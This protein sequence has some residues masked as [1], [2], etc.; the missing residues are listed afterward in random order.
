MG[1]LLNRRRYMGGGS[2]AMVEIEYLESTGTQYIKT[3]IIPI[4]SYV[5]ISFRF[6]W[7]GNTTNK[8]ETVFGFIKQSNLNRITFNKYQG[9]WMFGYNSTVSM[10]SVDSNIH[11]VLI[12]RYGE[13]NSAYFFC[14]IDNIRRGENKINAGQ[15]SLQI[16]LFG[17]NQSGT[18]VDNL[19]EI[20]LMSFHAKIYSDTMLQE[21]VNEYDYIPVRIGQIGYMYD[22]ISGQLLGNDG[23]GDFVIGPDKT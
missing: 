20:Q 13:G 21:L 15:E 3:P 4:N 12:S 16:Y 2:T 6:R 1:T 8:F 9:K 10:N 14:D 22:R 11:D 5:W 23:T 17:R 18:S 19:S 7:V